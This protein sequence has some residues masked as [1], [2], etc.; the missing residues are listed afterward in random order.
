MTIPHWKQRLQGARQREGRKRSA[1]WLHLA[2]VARDGSARVRTLVF[3]GWVGN[4]ALDLFSDQRSAKFEEIQ[5]QPQVEIC[6]LFPNAR[7]QYRL[8][9]LIHQLSAVEAPEICRQAWIALTASGRAL[10]GWPSPGQPFHKD[11]EFPDE[12]SAD[13]TPPNHFLILRLLIERVELLD[14]SCH[15]HQRLLWCRSTDWQ[16]QRLNP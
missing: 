3:R 12:I 11:A 10:W 1:R 16:E 13:T 5:H 6:W 15:P 4:E 2:T 8:R 7:H 14:L 9:G